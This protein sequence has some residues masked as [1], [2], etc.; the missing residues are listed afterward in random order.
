MPQLPSPF[1]AC[2]ALAWASS[3]LC[4]YH[5]LGAS[6]GSIV[7]S[8]Q[9]AKGRLAPKIPTHLTLFKKHTNILSKLWR[10][11][12]ISGMMRASLM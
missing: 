5:A 7:G 8:S 1:K 4:F 11:R 10:I 2:K 12:A 6:T 9:R 3:S